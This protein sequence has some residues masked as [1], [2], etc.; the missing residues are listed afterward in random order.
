MCLYQSHFFAK[1]LPRRLKIF[2][3]RKRLLYP[4]LITDG[5][6]FGKSVRESAMLKP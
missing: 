5:A 4:E 6:G 3:E 2:L 1:A